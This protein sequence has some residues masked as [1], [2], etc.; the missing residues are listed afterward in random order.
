MAEL[1]AQ[2]KEFVAG[3]QKS[4]DD[5]TFAPETLNPLQLRAVN[6]LIKSKV[7]KSKPLEEIY[8]ERTQAREDL[9][10]QE[11][12]AQD[13]LG[14]YL[15]MDESSVPGADFL[16]S[17]RSSAVLAGDLSA[18][19][20]A[21]NYMRDKIADAYK[22]TGMTG[23]K[24]T[25]GKKF[26]FEK[27]ANKLPGR[28]RFL[29]GAAQLAGKTLDLGERA[30]RSP[31]G[32][33]E[34][35]VAGAGTLGAGGGSVAY[36]LM[37]KTVGPSLMD[38]LLEDLGNMPKKDIDKLNIVDRAMVEAK[39]AAL[40]NFGAAALTPLLMASG[41]FL[42]FA[43]G[44]T[45][46]YQKAI[47]KFARDNGYE[48]P[49]LA[50]MRDG[51]LS[52]LGQ[53]YF[54]TVGVFPYISKTMDKRMLSAE[55]VFSKGFLDSN[56]ATIA[57]IYSHSF[58]SQRLYNQAVETFKK[59]VG[60]IDD[61]YDKFFALNTVA[62]D[63]AILKLP[64][65]LKATEDF[66]RQNSAQFPDIAQAFQRA[67]SGSVNRQ[68]FDFKAVQEMAGLQ[69]PLAQFMNFSN[70]VAR[71][72]PISFNQY[73]GM[74]MMLNQ[75]L[76]QTRYQTVN[77]SVAAI[78]EALEKDAHGFLKELNVP[79]LLQNKAIQQRMIELGGGDVAR[80]MAPE[81][82]A[83][84]LAE[85]GAIPTGQQAYNTAL[86]EAE[87]A[88]LKEGIDVTDDL[89]ARAAAKIAK[90]QG[91]KDT[92]DSIINAGSQ[93]HNSLKDANEV[94][95]RIMK[96][97]TGKEGTTAIGA[98]S[99][100]DKSLFT[101]KTL[102]NIPG[103]ATLP[104][105]K[106]FEKI[107]TAVFKSRSPA[108]LGEFRKM[109][110]AQPGFAG[111]SAAGEKLYQASV[112]RFMHNAFMSSFKSKPINAG[113]FGKARM[114]FSAPFENGAFRKLE[115]DPRFQNGVDDIY[116]A[117]ENVGTKQ[118]LASQGGEISSRITADGLED[119]TSIRFG[120]DDYRDFDGTTFRNI[121]GLDDPTIDV[122][123]FI[124]EMYGGGS[125]GA[126][127]RQHLED[128]VEYSKRL[129]DIPI[130]NSSSF[131]QRRLT[132]GGASSL[133][134]VALG[135]GGSAAA[136]PLAPFILFATALR[137]GKILSDPYLLRQINDVLTP[138][139]V[140]AI[141]KGGKAFG[142]TQAGVINP[143]AYLAGLRTKREAFARFMNKAFGDDDDYVPVDPKN[144]DL[145][146]ITE[147]LNQKN[148]EM[149]KPNY[150]NNAGNV[151]MKTIQQMYDEEVM[152]APKEEEQAEEENFIEG[153]L[154]A[155][156][157]FNSTFL[158]VSQANKLEPGGEPSPV[159]QQMPINQGQM[160][161]AT[162]QV[163]PQQVSALFPNDPLSAQIAA[164]RQT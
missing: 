102:F 69:D 87:E 2:Q 149:I 101:Q 62:G 43:F 79:S 29:K 19:F 142:T 111:Y 104:K 46:E 42:N 97:Y 37:N 25:Q 91:G 74:T 157:E 53:S 9:A 103:A 98:L 6:K 18:S 151:P 33:G 150:G 140:E 75:A 52:G 56:I 41:K 31:L 67:T 115:A 84:R 35:A 159:N 120:P 124:E 144:I 36:D 59:N 23:M 7:L 49:L 45:G 134:G 114:P 109:I 44:T 58:L 57:P 105:D 154:I 160:Q 85:S 34:L 125:K 145:K 94:F 110:G 153:G 135:F 28:Y 132:L 24:L 11:T 86:K 123:K 119:V 89:T 16:L 20:M 54:K 133:A 65:T 158:P 55:K 77:K 121:L 47:A 126:T 12:V 15:G 106:L 66:L 152:E 1:N 60:T 113:L 83:A 27:L 100:F 148:V 122:K 76:E 38:S 8:K 48:I 39:N 17:G 127:A 13:P 147:Y 78:R 3:L 88:I 139:E 95:S 26:F 22:Q 143:K 50:A 163:T 129:T 21:A 61:A 164:R 161:P 51:P 131:I 81:L 80:I 68:A 73:K 90:T 32:R 108:A 156:N 107:Q 72:E 118:A 155:Q 146:R 130:T 70:A 63:P 71:G 162:G 128:F 40:F 138:K 64:K 10:K 92:L 93:M 137:A 112:A 5:N 99:K 116:E 4:I 14:A 141:L 82:A 30:V 96:F 117:M 136:S